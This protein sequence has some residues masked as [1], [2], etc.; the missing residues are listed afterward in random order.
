MKKSDKALIVML[1]SAL[2]FI[3]VTVGVAALLSPSRDS[4]SL[5]KSLKG[6]TVAD[7]IDGVI[8]SVVLELP[9]YGDCKVEIRRAGKN[10]LSF[11]GE[12]NSVLKRELDN[13]VLTMSF[14]DNFDEYFKGEFV[15]FVASD[16]ESLRQSGVCDKL[17]LTDFKTKEMKLTVAGEVFLNR[18]VFSRLDVDYSESYSW[19]NFNIDGSATA[20]D[21]LAV[22]SP[23]S[24]I[25]ITTEADNLKNKVTLITS[26][27]R[28]SDNGEDVVVKESSGITVK[29]KGPSP[30]TILMGSPQKPIGIYYDR[31][32]RLPAASDSV[33]IENEINL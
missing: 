27:S 30:E 16:I 17:T 24:D 3:V 28:D 8:N 12:Y 32:V 5:D 31:E 19:I 1:F 15:L 25:V 21:T 11:P 22:N 13:G 18:C 29:F 14:P 9:D 23:V 2:A 33:L 7:D 6:R 4:S 26:E 10:R 20:V